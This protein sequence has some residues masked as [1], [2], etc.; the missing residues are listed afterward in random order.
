MSA[1]QSL[2]TQLHLLIPTAES[3]QHFISRRARLCCGHGLVHFV[4]TSESETKLIQTNGLANE[5]KTSSHS[6]PMDYMHV[7]NCKQHF[8]ILTKGECHVTGINGLVHHY[9]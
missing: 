7:L 4:S 8:H 2:K 9:H 6:A 3:Q 1:R 5:N